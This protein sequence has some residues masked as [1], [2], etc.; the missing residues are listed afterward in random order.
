MHCLLLRDITTV[1]E[2]GELFDVVQPKRNGMLNQDTGTDIISHKDAVDGL[3]VPTVLH[4]VILA[5]SWSIPCFV[6]VIVLLVAFV[7][8]RSA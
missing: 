4:P 2:E 8:L 5:A 6:V 1:E 3:I 7:Y